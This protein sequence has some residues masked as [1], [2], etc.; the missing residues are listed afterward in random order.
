M[1]TENRKCDG[2]RVFVDDA[3]GSSAG[4]AQEGIGNM[5]NMD[6]LLCT[7][8]RIRRLCCLNYG[9]YKGW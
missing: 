5:A 7:F 4:A 1:R 3:M 8:G 9:S 6:S 2:S